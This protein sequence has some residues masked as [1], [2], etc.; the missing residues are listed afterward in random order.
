MVERWSAGVL[1]CWSLRIFTRASPSGL[2]PLIGGPFLR[3]VTLFCRHHKDLT[4]EWFML[5]IRLN[6]FFLLLQRALFPH[7]L[8]DVPK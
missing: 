4:D 6:E 8:E 7:S 2:R 1:E 5:E 3:W